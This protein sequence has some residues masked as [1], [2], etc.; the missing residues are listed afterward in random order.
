MMLKFITFWL[1][2]C[3]I[4]ILPH[5]LLANPVGNDDLNLW[6]GPM[7]QPGMGKPIPIW[8]LVHFKSYINGGFIFSKF[9]MQNN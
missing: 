7:K 1:I 2:I 4:L 5:E 3:T 6:Q 8:I 9:L